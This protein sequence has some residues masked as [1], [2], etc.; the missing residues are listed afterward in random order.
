[1]GYVVPLILLRVIYNNNKY[2][3]QDYDE[4]K[5]TAHVMSSVFLYFSYLNLDNAEAIAEST[6]T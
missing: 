5:N 1:M 2:L 6:A 3:T 4:N